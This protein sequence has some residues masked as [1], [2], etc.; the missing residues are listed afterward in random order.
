MS[1]LSWLRAARY[2]IFA[3]SFAAAFA[4]A[5]VDQACSETGPDADPRTNGCLTEGCLEAG[6]GGDGG[7]GGNDAGPDAPPIVYPDPLDGTSKAATKVKGDF[8]FVEGP[9]WIANKLYFTDVSAN[10]IHTLDGTTTAVWRNNSNGANGLGIDKDGRLL[11]CEGNAHQVTRSDSAQGSSRNV[12]YGTFNGKKLNSPNDVVARKDN[13]IYF[14]DPDYGGT[15]PASNQLPYQGVYRIDKLGGLERVAGTFNKANGIGVAP[16]QSTLYVVDNGAGTLLAG[17]IDADGK[18]SALAK[19]ADV[20]GGD[21]MAVDDAGN[22]YVADDNGIDVFD[23]TGKPRGTINVPVKASNCTFGGA[24]RKTLYITANGPA[25]D[26]GN[27]PAT[28]VY[29]IVLNVP[30]LP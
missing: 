14:T 5:V 13:N 30:G 27:N 1:K 21:G 7:P 26:G 15:D 3:P 9:V 29:S 10:R 4:I 19:I 24:D 17:P 23:K 22:L 6:S 18:P 2:A 20:P 25:I 12:L 28:G 16:D 11:V 8:G